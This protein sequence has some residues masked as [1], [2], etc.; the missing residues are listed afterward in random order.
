MLRV[1]AISHRGNQSPC[2]F[3]RIAQPLQ[4]LREQGLVEYSQVEVTPLWF[5]QPGKYW[6]L[7]R[8]LPAWDVVWIARPS[9]SA[10]LP[11]IR[12]ARLLGKP[13]MVDLDDWLLDL[14]EQHRDAPYFRSRPFLE[15]MRAALRAAD[16]VTVSTPLIAEHCGR[17]GLK[18]FVL[19]NTIDLRQFTQG[20]RAE[21]P[22]TI[23]YCGGLSHGPDVALVSGA[24]RRLLVDKAMN[25]RVVT[26]G[27]PI[28]DL[29]GLPGYTHLS[30][31]P[32]TAYPAL[33]SRLTIDI[34]LAPLCDGAFNR[35]KSEIKYL[36]YTAAGAVT[37]ASDVLPYNGAIAADRGYLVGQSG[38]DAWYDAI[39]RLVEDKNLRTRLAAGAMAWVRGERSLEARANLWL[40]A[41][42]DVVRGYDPAAAPDAPLLRS[43]LYRRHMGNIAIRETLVLARVAP[44]MLRHWLQ[45]L[46]VRGAHV[47]LARRR[48][49]HRIGSNP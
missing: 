22:V 14:P 30:G 40:Q 34:G 41:F 26:V 29:L 17:L 16:A 11:F 48:D 5:L 21:G 47:R 28:P 8:D 42:Q 23:A 44:S 6:R 20:Q 39:K 9:F 3:Q 27:C 45:S 46:T 37:V 24:L 36:E 4:A 35:A 18:T 7:L 19:P 10:V 31:V 12:R 13:V 38:A 15:G 49:A 2:T 25:V 33:L 32:A 1:L 43:P